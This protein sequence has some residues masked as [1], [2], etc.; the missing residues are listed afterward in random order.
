[1]L[2][3]DEIRTSAEAMREKYPGPW[4]AVGADWNLQGFPQVEY[5]DKMMSYIK[6]H[7][8]IS[9]RYFVAVQ[10]DNLIALLD[11]IAELEAAQR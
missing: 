8:G 6:V 1:M 4:T 7:D 5:S 2:D 9:A 10:P 11:K 3:L